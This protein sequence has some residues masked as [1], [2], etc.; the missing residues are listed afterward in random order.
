MALRPPESFTYRDPKQPKTTK[1][2]S[3]NGMAK[4]DTFP[5][6][7]GTARH[8]ADMER[9]AFVF[10][11]SRDGHLEAFHFS[12]SRAVREPIGRRSS[13]AVQIV[14]CARVICAAEVSHLYTQQ[15][16]PRDFPWWGVPICES[17]SKLSQTRNLFQLALFELL[18][19]FRVAHRR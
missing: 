17:H 4:R 12:F 15:Q 11:R 14:W 7:G 16:R 1:S 8:G 18:V 5:P 6:E 19:D 2:A 9:S 13:S 10:S 3:H